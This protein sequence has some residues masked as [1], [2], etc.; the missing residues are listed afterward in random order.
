[1]KKMFERMIAERQR[2]ASKYRSE[3]D[4]KSA[5]IL[6]QK[7]RE[8]KR[9]L[10]EA[11]RKAQEV[12]GQADAE[13]TKIYAQAYSVDPEFYQF[14]K[15]L[16]TYKT[17]LEKETWLLLSTDAEFLKYLKGSEIR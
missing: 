14:M 12:K 17:S 5:E 1:V 3:G 2:I 9:I 16:E 15:S 4:G 8:L 7:E 10:S 11:Y 6:G 13:A